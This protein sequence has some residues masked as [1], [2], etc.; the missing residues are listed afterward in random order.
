MDNISV[1]RI[2]GIKIQ[3]EV[4]ERVLKW[5]LEVYFPLLITIPGYEEIHWYQRIKGGPEY[6]KNLAIFHY[7]NRRSPVEVRSDQKWKD[8]QKDAETT[9]GSSRFENTWFPAYEQI[10]SFNKDLTNQSRSLVTETEKPLIIHLEGYAFSNLEQE[11][12]DTWFDKSGEEAFIPLLMRL[13][14]L[15]EYNR[16]KLIDVDPT[17]LTTIQIEKHPIEYPPRLS[18]LTFDNFRSF[19]NYENSVEHT[20][21]ERAVEA[22]FPLGLNYQW[23]VQYQLMQSWRK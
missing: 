3:R 22:P 5:R 7:T 14:G 19:E 1:I 16:Y 8:I 13:L 17:G 23:Y 20:A 9:W 18:I 21:F 6:P 12:Y 11:K 2:Q 15:I 4:E 10:S